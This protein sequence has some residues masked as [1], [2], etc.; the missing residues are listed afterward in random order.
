MD[1][2]R[3]SGEAGSGAGG[4]RQVRPTFAQVDPLFAVPFLHALRLPASA[5]TRAAA[6]WLT[7]AV[8]RTPGDLCAHV[9]RIYARQDLG[10]PIGLADALADLWIAL[11]TS[12]R[13][14]RERMLRAVAHDLPDG[15]VDCFVEGGRLGNGDLPWDGCPVLA[16]GYTQRP[17]VI[18][19]S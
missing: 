12:G 13:R 19:R 4:E 3:G 8:A 2:T 14:L 17:L 9:L 15:A 16:A 18:V 5:C 10:D 11:G 1:S 7:H 6:D